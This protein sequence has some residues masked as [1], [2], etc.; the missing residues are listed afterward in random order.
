MGLNKVA[1]DPSTHFVEKKFDCKL[2]AKLTKEL[3]LMKGTKAYDSK[4]I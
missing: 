4:D 1:D 3:K 2:A